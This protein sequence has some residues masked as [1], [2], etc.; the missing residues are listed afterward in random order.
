MWLIYNIETGAQSGEWVADEPAPD[1]GMAAVQVPGS[2]RMGIST[3]DAAARGFV[4]P[5]RLT[6][7]QVQQLF[8]PAE[9]LAGAQAVLD[10]ALDLALRAQLLA[11]MQALTMVDSILLTEPLFVQGVPLW[12]A[13]GALASARQADVLAGIPPA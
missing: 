6:R 9:W 10:P 3:W 1:A 5:V 8:T 12:V 11:L 4:D 2:A 7:A 13:A